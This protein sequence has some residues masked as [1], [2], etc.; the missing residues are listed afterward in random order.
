MQYLM[1]KQATVK[2]DN[3]KDPGAVQDDGQSMASDDDII[4]QD[5]MNTGKKRNPQNKKPFDPKSSV[6][7]D[8]EGKPIK[9][10]KAKMTGNAGIE[11]K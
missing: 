4:M 9:F 6:T 7:Y 2:D 10:N 1:Q 3:T 5:M 11:K 8:F